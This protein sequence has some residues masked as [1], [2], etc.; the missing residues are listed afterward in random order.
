MKI[1]P[2]SNIIQEFCNELNI[3]LKERYLYK[4]NVCYATNFWKVITSHKRSKLELYI[5]YWNYH[6]DNDLTLISVVLARIYF[7]DQR[8]GNGRSLLEFFC[9]CAKKYDVQ[10]IYIESA[11]P[12][13]SKFAKKY[14][15]ELSN[16]K[17]TWS[18]DTSYLNEILFIK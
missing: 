8:I 3:Y 14:K 13:S 6:I 9:K 7:R 5:R 15:F 1:L 16:I 2:T 17:W 10:K 4:K 11:N 18:I 12:A